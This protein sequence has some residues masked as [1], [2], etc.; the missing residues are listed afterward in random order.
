MTFSNNLIE[1]KRYGKI[2]KEKL[3]QDMPI[4]QQE[5]ILWMLDHIGHSNLGDNGF[6]R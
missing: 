6:W 3:A 1:K 4:Y 2:L 5:E